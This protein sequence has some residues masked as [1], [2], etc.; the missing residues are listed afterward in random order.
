[1]TM[2][3]LVP[4]GMGGSETYARAIAAELVTRDDVELTTVVPGPARG[5]EPRAREVCVDEVAGGP[6]A[7][8]RVGALVRSRLARRGVRRELGDV[9]VLHV[10][11]TT[12]TPPPA[13][14]QALVQTLHDVQHLDLPELFGVAERAYRRVAYERWARRSDAVLTV[15][16]FAKDR[17]VHHLGI[18]PER[19][20]VAHLGVDRTQFTP[21]L[22]ARE[23]FLYYPARGWA[24]KNH[25]VL[26]EAVA[27]LRRERP[28]LRLV[29]TGGALDRLGT[30]PEWVEVRGHVTW[31]E[32]RDLYRR[33][34]ALVFPSLYEGFGL[35]PIEAMASGCPVAASAAGSLPEICGDAAE[36]FDP[37]DPAAVA[38]GVQ[39]ALDRSHE[40]AQRGL[41]RAARFT[42][43]ACADAHVAAFRAAV[44]S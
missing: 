43:Q 23:D 14:G 12:V 26:V 40:L 42:W 35:P 29:L 18:A 39:R 34:A 21:Q 30:L 22:G 15:S 41:V 19:V 9:D 6:S 31:D 25:A 32:V 36:M 27:L 3:T 7:T 17:I 44:S 38:A 20:H 16:R 33:A 24:H 13:R 11:F 28:G 10:P 5:F 2:L 37:T 8:D 4:G 1:M